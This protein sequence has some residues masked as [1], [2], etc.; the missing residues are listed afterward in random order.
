MPADYPDAAALQAVERELSTLPPLVFAGEARRLKGALAEAAEGR[1]F[2]LQGGDCAESFKEFHADNIRDF[3]RLLLQ[4]AVVLTFAGKKPVIKVGRIAGQFAKPRSEP[5]ET[6]DGVTLPSYRG[7]N[8]NGQDFDLASRLPDPQRLLKAY[9]QSSATLNLIRAYA[10]GGFADL[11]NIHGWTLGFVEGSPNA[12]RYREMSDKI[13]EALEFMAAIGIT[14]ET[15]PT[16][17]Q[18]DVFTS[19][20]ALLLGY[21]QAMTRLDSSSGG[22]F[23]TSAHMLWIGERTRQRDGAHVEYMR[24]IEN[25]IGLKCGPSLEPDE[26]I[27]LID[28]L[29]PKNEA[30]RLTLIGRFGYDKIEA[31]LPRAGGGGS[32]RG[33]QGRLVVRSHARQHPE[34]GQRL[35]DPPVRPNPVGGEELPR[36][37]ERA[38]RPSRRCAPGDDRPE[39]HRMPGRRPRAQRGRAEPPLPHALRPAAERRPGAGALFPDRRTP[40][41]RARRGA[42]GRLVLK[43]AP[44]AIVQNAYVVR[45]LE[46]ACARLNR[47]YGI[48]PFLGGSEVELASHVHRGRPAAPIV[49]RGV[50]VQAG[51]LNLE[52]IQ[53]VSSGP[54]AFHDMFPDGGEGLHHV[55]MFCDH[56][57][58]TRDRLVAAGCP[59]ASE[60][61]FGP[62]A[63]IAYIDAR[64]DLGHMIELYPEDPLIRDMYAQARDAA[65]GWDGRELIRPFRLA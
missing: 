38:G 35:Q 62:E 44:A 34:G 16:L 59:V 19:H 23:D 64:A 17:K 24:G 14:P 9:G 57:A 27:R 49:I 56:Y 12:A 13:S 43:V 22:W 31:R 52:L 30:G 45:D 61:A 58:A 29:N 51:D 42:A 7:D 33:A 1:A 8:I 25:P 46:A 53:L 15:Q 26:L 10:Q 3:F 11:H 47:V 55:A 63:S 40:A 60:F 18:V 65:Q 28:V 5:T 48:G 50:F 6:I 4:M 41:R 36:G 37:G 2:L 39:R 20:E 21:E 32:A 54:S